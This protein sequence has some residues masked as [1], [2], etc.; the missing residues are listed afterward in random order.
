MYGRRGK[1][2]PG[3]ID[4][5]NRIKGDVWRKIALT[6]KPPVCEECGRKTKGRKLHVHHKDKNRKNND[7]SNLQ[8]VCS[9]CHNNKIHKRERDHLGRFTGKEVV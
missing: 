1:D 3:W 8:V 4:G 2:A 9:Y 6:H 7:L 5:R